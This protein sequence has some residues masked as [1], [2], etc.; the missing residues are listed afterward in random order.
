MKSNLIKSFLNLPFTQ[1][2]KST[3]RIQSTESLFKRII[4][5]ILDDDFWG[6]QVSILGNSV[7]IVTILVSTFDYILSSGTGGTL[8]INFFIEGFVIALFT[9][10]YLLRILFSPSLGFATRAS[11]LFSFYGIIDVLS[12]TPLLLDVLSLPMLGGL[13]ALRILRL[14]RVARYIP[15][16]NVISNAFNARKEDILTSLLGVMLLSLTL[17]ALMFHYESA[18][19]QCSFNNILEVFVWSIGKYTGDYGSIAEITPISE[20]GKIIATINGL[21]GIALFAVPAGLLASAFIEQLEE[22]RHK[23]I[24]DERIGSISRHFEKKT[25]GGKDF[26][27]DAFPRFASL[28]FLQVKFLLSEQEIMETIRESKNLRFRA[29]KSKP[30]NAFSDIRIVESFQTNCSYGFRQFNEESKLVLINAIGENERGISH[31]AYTLAAGL[32]VNYIAR[33]V[34]ILNLNQAPVGG[35]TS[36]DYERYLQGETQTLNPALSEFLSDIESFD[37][38]TYFIILSSAASG[39]SDFVVEYGNDL[40]ST[41]FVQDKTSLNREKDLTELMQILEKNLHNV[42][43]RGANKVRL[44]YDFTLE[45]NTIGNR[46]SNSLHHLVRQKT[47]GNVVSLYTNIKILTG[48]NNQ[49]YAA[50]TALSSIFEDIQAATSAS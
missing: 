21:L 46:N 27:F 13:G 48:E 25:G 12:L 23:Q 3:A 33:E 22:K 8:V 35:N 40:G 34:L 7:I 16:F 45:Q 20:M 43:Y 9:A 36:K 28:D 30:E 50:C 14:W 2:S 38:Q 37:S 10:E 1:P 44:E 15:S 39:R 41:E 31:L 26:K 24:I 47:G 4:I 29:L 5:D 49:Y 19:A 6:S 11:Y 32:N 42:E 17:S 18:Y